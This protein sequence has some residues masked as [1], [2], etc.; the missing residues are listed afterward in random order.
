MVERVAVDVAPPYEDQS[1]HGG[2]VHLMFL[3]QELHGLFGQEST[4][5]QYR[6][7]SC[8]AWAPVRQRQGDQDLA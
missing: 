5:Q 7:P 6:K 4:L 3:V 1:G 8:E 2:A